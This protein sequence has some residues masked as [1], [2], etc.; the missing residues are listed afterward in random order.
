M[1]HLISIVQNSNCV[2]KRE[3]AP[4]VSEDLDIV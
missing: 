1:K 4:D 3:K 2:P